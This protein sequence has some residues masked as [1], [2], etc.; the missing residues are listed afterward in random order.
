MKGSGAATHRSGAHFDD[1]GYTAHN[2]KCSPPTSG[3]ESHSFPTPSP[4]DH[5][6]PR[7]GQFKDVASSGQPAGKTKT[8]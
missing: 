5:C 3:K 4:S 6:N 8:F 1:R 7:L 2:S